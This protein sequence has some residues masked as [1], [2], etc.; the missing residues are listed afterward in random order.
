MIEKEVNEP[1]Q[2][3]QSI[4]R[5]RVY[6]YQAEPFSVRTYYAQLL[7]CWIVV[8]EAILAWTF[9]LYFKLLLLAPLQEP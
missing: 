3:E 4:L 8:N 9:V 1:R 5:G 2:Y 6:D 7:L